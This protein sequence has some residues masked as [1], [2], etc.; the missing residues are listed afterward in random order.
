MAPYIALHKSFLQ[1]KYCTQFCLFVLAN[2]MQACK[3]QIFGYLWHCYS[4]QMPSSRLKCGKKLRNT[5]PSRFVSTA[6][7][8][9]LL[10]A[11]YIEY[12]N[13][14]Y[15]LSVCSGQS[16]ACIQNINQDLGTLEPCFYFLNA[17][18]PYG[19]NLAQC[20]GI[21]PQVV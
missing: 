9:L 16:N 4:S 15:I 21:C 19:F 3:T 8:K 11:K 6:L 20:R 14:M 5:S 2:Q 12:C 10:Q 1:G 17:R 13:C 7:H 18:L